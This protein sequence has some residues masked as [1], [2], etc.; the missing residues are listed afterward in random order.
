MNADID[1]I[2]E[3]FVS[4]IMPTYNCELYIEAAIRSVVGQ[5]YRNWELIVIDDGSTDSTFTIA[6]RLA[7]EDSRIKLIQNSTNMGVAKTRNR[8]FDLSRG[9]YVALLD[10]DDIWHSSKL[11]KQLALAE[12]TGADVIY[13]SYGII[14]ENG[15]KLCSDFIVPETTDYDDMLVSSVIN[16]STALL[17]KNIAENYSFCSDYYHEDLLLWLKI[18]RDNK[19]ARGVVEILADYRVSRGSRSFNKLHS[20]IHRWKIYRKCM[21]EPFF[22]SVSLIIQYAI[23]AVKKYYKKYD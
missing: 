12:S 5:T 21:K 15:N 17:S 9:E 4:I 14:D 16:C 18:M 23:L 1:K 20:A 19:Q 10:S 7:T 6:Q 11:E 3:P 13:C 8:G 22:R 2:T